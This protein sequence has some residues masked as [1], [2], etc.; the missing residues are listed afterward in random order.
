[1]GDINILLNNLTEEHIQEVFK[2]I[3][4]IEETGN[5]EDIR[6]LLTF[7]ELEQFPPHVNF[8]TVKKVKFS[9]IKTL[10]HLKEKDSLDILIKMLNKGK[11]RMKNAVSE[12][13]GNIG[14]EI[15]VEP[16]IE[17]LK[18]DT[19]RVSAIKAL[20]QIGSNK[21]IDCLLEMLHD[22]DP[23]VRSAAATSLG[24]IKDPKALEEL[25][26]ALEEDSDVNVRRL[27]SI[28]IG[29]IGQESSVP[30]LIKKLDDQFLNVAT[31][32]ADS[33]IKI[34]NPSVKPLVEVI[35]NRLAADALIKIGE[36]SVDELIKALTSEN[37]NIRTIAAKCL[38]KIKSEKSVKFLVRELKN[39]SDKTL[40]IM[41]DSI[42]FICSSS[43]MPLAEELNSADEITQDLVVE[44]FFDIGHL[45]DNGLERLR[46]E[47]NTLNPVF[48]KLIIRAL[49]K[50]NDR[51][52]IP[53]LSNIFLS[54]P[55]IDVKKEILKT[56][57]KLVPGEDM[58]EVFQHAMEHSDMEIKELA[59]RA[60][61]TSG[62]S[63]ACNI[64]IKFLGEADENVKMVIVKS[65]G[66]ISH[67]YTVNPL[68]KALK[69]DDLPLKL[70]VIE[71]LGNKH[72]EEA[73]SAL[74]NMLQ[75]E[76]TEVKL[77]TIKSL[78]KIG[79][80]SAVPALKLLMRNS[81]ADVKQEVEI[82]LEEMEGPKSFWSRL[83]G[84]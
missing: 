24:Q 80:K 39:N 82:A 21:A 67:E 8:E 73:T 63:S 12:A 77:L 81:V 5:K 62:S 57:N 74:I 13:L 22:R 65:L 32:S 44:I 56:I 1:M 48:Q 33:L 25:T 76:S 40:K 75:E 60:I 54:T 71:A 50:L 14:S 15:A 69:T 83:F 16:L 28:A 3:K 35:E 9:I 61:A 43:L 37:E 68:L 10:G 52:S 41:R 18:D 38:G 29:E 17:T 45:T 2:N 78:K 53:L 66:S 59:V 51:D 47:L 30:V 7:L 72:D 49:G 58:V 79:D 34:G 64:L 42:F 4:E 23:E 19:A 55:H 46:N 70:A 36:A 11:T 27:A 20:G 31:S 84:A 6:K 26:K